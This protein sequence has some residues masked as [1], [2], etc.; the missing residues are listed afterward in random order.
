MTGVLHRIAYFGK[1]PGYGDF[2]RSPGEQVL[3]E[4]MDQWLA[5]VMQR[6]SLNPRWRQHYDT[7]P[8]L[9]FAFVGT[10]SQQVVSGHL[11]ASRDLS[12]R[13]FPF[14][15]M[16]VHQVQ[17]PR[18]FLPFGPLALAAAWDILAG[19]AAAA[20]ACA[21]RPAEGAL[22]AP[23][24]ARA[25]ASFDDYLAG[26]CLADL[27][28]GLG[29]RVQ[30][31]RLLLAL[32][33]LLSPLHQPGPAPSHCLALPLP[34]ELPMRR[35]VAT[36]WMALAAPLL[37]RRDLELAMFFAQVAGQPSLVLG[38]D[39]ANP[40]SLRAIIDPDAVRDDMV[41]MDDCGW[42]DGALQG[43]AALQRLAACL[44]QGQMGLPTAMQL[45]QE[46][47]C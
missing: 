33:L 5:T 37:A 26:A 36:F 19:V 32:G 7:C 9:D 13:R 18:D 38:L 8:P 40:S 30:A 35:S 29:G 15:C 47:F 11:M 41:V 28:A 20:G 25:Q 12:E 46:T 22:P 17:K 27:E 24:V 3:V 14:V 10:R 44:E 1:L 2:V 43:D 34:Q 45:F 23:D 4:L 42:V 31:K 6:L 21:V 16:A 39:G